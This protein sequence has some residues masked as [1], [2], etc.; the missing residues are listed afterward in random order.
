MQMS[1][2]TICI[3]TQK[4]TLTVQDVYKIFQYIAPPSHTLLHRNRSL[5]YSAK[6]LLVFNF[7]NFQP[8]AKIFQQKFLIRSVR[9]ARASEFVSTKSSKIAIRENLYPRKFSTIRYA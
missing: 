7:A 5:S 6:F 4:Y 8:F 3:A 9:C 2:L 1:L